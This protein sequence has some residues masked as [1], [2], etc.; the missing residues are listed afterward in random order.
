MYELNNGS[1]ISLIVDTD[2]RWEISYEIYPIQ[3][4]HAASIA[5]MISKD[6]FFQDVDINFLSHMGRVTSIVLKVD[7][8]W[9]DLA[10]MSDEV[11]RRLDHLI[12]EYL[13]VNGGYEEVQA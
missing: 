2:V 1:P 9:L 3:L 6:E 11:E 5:E 4:R 12:E 13:A 7:Q 10:S 8:Y